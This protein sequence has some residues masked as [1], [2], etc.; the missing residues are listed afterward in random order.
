[1]K[2]KEKT[3]SLLLIKN[4]LQ[5]QCAATSTTQLTMMMSN[6]SKEAPGS[7]LT[8][9]VALTSK[10]AEIA[11]EMEFEETKRENMFLTFNQE[12]S[13]TSA[14]DFLTFTQEHSTTSVNSNINNVS[15]NVSLFCQMGDVLMLLIEEI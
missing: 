14:H 13:M 12:Y 15:H 2:E 11:I 6:F 8:S 4:A 10:H 1:M 7:L 3:H 5:H 9:T